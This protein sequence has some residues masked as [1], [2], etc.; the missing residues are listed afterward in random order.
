VSGALLMELE[1]SL[2]FGL[3]PRRL[4]IFEDRIEVRDFELLRERVESRRYGWV[5]GVVVAGGDRFVSLL[6]TGQD[7][8]PVLIRGLGKRTAERARTLIEERMIRANEHP[9]VSPP[10]QPGTERLIRDLAELR[11][12]GVLSEEEFETKRKEVMANEQG[13]R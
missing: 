11:D 4:L 1:E 3:W 10:A 5:D 7:S 6:I 13:C 12:A 8:K 9:S 2:M